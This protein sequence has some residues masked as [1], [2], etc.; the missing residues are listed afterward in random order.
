MKRNLKTNPEAKKFAQFA[1]ALKCSIEEIITKVIN[2][3]LPFWVIVT[4]VQQ[5]RVHRHFTLE[6][7]L[8]LKLQS[9]SNKWEYIQ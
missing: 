7:Q 5:L 9:E 3:T 4:V 1:S 6:S 8:C 2:L